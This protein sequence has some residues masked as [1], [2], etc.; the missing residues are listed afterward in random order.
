M[1]NAI[2]FVQAF[3]AERF[4]FGRERRTS[5]HLC[6]VVVAIVRELLQNQKFR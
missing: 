1:I 2:R 5:A 3:S 6:D 4:F